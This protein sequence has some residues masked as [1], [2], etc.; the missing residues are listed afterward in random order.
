MAF[1]HKFSYEEKV[2]ILSEYLE[3]TYGFREICNQYKINQGSLKI[4]KDYMKPSAGV[5]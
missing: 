1:K 4:G 5:D 3:G 2:R